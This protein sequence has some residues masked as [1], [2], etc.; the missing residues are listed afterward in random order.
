MSSQFSVDSR[1][2]VVGAYAV[3]GNRL[4]TL[5]TRIQ[6]ALSE[7]QSKASNDLIVASDEII[8]RFN[9]LERLLCSHTN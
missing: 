4:T 7:T 3:V 6:A 5:E 9:S 1:D 2:L 8:S